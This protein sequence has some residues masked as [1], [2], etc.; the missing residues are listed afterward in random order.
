MADCRAGGDQTGYSQ[1]NRTF[2]QQIKN[3][4]HQ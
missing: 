4:A 1:G 3:P 2:H